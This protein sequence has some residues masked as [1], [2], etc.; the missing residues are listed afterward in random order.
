M[1]YRK[2]ARTLIPALAL[3]TTPA[4]ALADTPRNYFGLDMLS[5]TFDDDGGAFA[6]DFDERSAG[7]RLSRGFNFNHWLGLEAAVQSLGNYDDGNDRELRYRAM[8][9]SGVG[10]I[11]VTGNLEAY[12]R[13][14]LGVTR[15]RI[16]PDNDSN[17]TD[18]KPLGTAGLGLEYRV[19]DRFS[20]RGGVDRYG[21]EARVGA[22]TT[23]SEQRVNQTIDTAYIGITRS[24]G[25]AE[26]SKRKGH[27][28]MHMR[29]QHQRMH[30][31]DAPETDTEE[32]NTDE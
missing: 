29:Q 30:E 19:S 15:V 11:P 21:F 25:W 14:G 13:L 4:L 5:A 26:R 23:G 3:A 6:S 2:L 10:R 31:K 18:T 7:M 1:R 9:F 32:Q 12:G 22:G 20:I 17:R 16:E 28:R 8:T 27:W 24:F